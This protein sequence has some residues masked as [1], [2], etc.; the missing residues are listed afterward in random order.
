[1]GERKPRILI[2]GG[3]A[4]EAL[5]ILYPYFSLLEEGWEVEI[6]APSKDVIKTVV[7]DFEPGWATYTEKLGY[8]W[9]PDK[10]FREIN[11]EEY[12]GLVIPGGRL[13]EYIRL[14]EDV[15]RIVKHFLE[16]GKPVAA[17]CHAPLVLVAVAPEKLRGRTMTSYIAVKP[18]VENAGA[19]WVDREVVVDGNLVTSRAWPDNPAWMREFKKLVR[20][21]TSA[22]G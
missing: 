5:E 6:A 14:D 11:P 7:H 18:E 17:I 8:R 4:A 20:E 13:P 2:L 12:D 9:K 21:R 3:D 19:K 1:M 10:T 15:K 22:Q 16:T